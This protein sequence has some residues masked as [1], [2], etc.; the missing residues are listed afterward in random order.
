M[1]TTPRFPRETKEVE[2]D[3]FVKEKKRPSREHS[4]AREGSEMAV[5]VAAGRQQS[6]L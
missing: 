5:A 3:T 2:R 4:D 1:K 6:F